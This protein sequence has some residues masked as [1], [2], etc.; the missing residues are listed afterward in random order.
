MARGREARA[1]WQS[2]R[3]APFRLVHRTKQLC[4]FHHSVSPR[5]YPIFLVNNPCLG[6]EWLVFFGPR[7][8]RQ[9]SLAVVTKAAGLSFLAEVIEQ[10]LAATVADL[11]IRPH[12]LK[13][14]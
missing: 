14:G 12:L 8:L 5:P 6:R 11:R 4:C 1:P 2:L 13:L 7:L 10:I 9:S 3:R